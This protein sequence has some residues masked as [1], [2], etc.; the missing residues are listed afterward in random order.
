MKKP[1]HQIPLR[2]LFETTS[3]TFSSDK[4]SKR[5]ANFLPIKKLIQKICIN[6][7]SRFAV[8]FH[9]FLVLPF[10]LQNQY[11]LAKSHL[12]SRHPTTA[13]ICCLSPQQQVHDSIPIY[14]HQI[15]VIGILKQNQTLLSKEQYSSNS[16]SQTLC[17]S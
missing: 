4:K 3:S 10:L 14:L 9:N 16:A 5:P 17:C 1:I 12:F 13:S 6:N 7:N 15:L 2:L 11:L 8:A